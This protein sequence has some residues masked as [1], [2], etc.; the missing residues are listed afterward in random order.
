MSRDQKIRHD[1]FEI[2]KLL[3]EAGANLD[4]QDNNGQTALMVASI[5]NPDTLIIDYFIE[6][7]ASLRLKDKEERDVTYYLRSNLL[8]SPKDKA[9]VLHQISEALNTDAKK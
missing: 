2:V 5:T 6:K 8:L 7:G 1:S 4:I 3:V 9:R